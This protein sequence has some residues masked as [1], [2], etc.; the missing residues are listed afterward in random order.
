MIPSN[1]FYD[2]AAE[3]F[4]ILHYLAASFV[5][6]QLYRAFASYTRA[7][8]VRGLPVKYRSSFVLDLCL[9]LFRAS[10]PGAL[11]FPD[12]QEHHPVIRYRPGK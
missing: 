2:T 9:L 12:R 10:F 7:L 1:L 3:D 4:N 5:K 6:K 11:R 8:Y